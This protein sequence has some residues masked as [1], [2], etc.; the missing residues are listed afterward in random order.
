M[1]HVSY[2]ELKNWDT[3]AFYHKLVHIDKLKLFKGNEYTAFGNAIHD[4]CEQLLLNEKLEATEHFLESY[5]NVLN[6]LAKDNYD[7]NKKLVLDMKDQGLR[8]LP[9]VMPAL[10]KYFGSYEVVATEEMLYEPIE[11]ADFSFKG[12]IDLVVKTEDGR[13]H[14]IDWKTCSWGWNAKKKSDKM[15]VYQL[16]FYKHFYAS[17]HNIDPD[18]ID[19][20]FGLLKRTAKKNEVEL[21]KVSSGKKRTENALNFLE[22][23]L[24]NIVNKKYIKNKLACN[25]PFGPCEF[26]GTKHCP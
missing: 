23:A 24:Y 22:N 11:I 21:F 4:T 14:V 5:K 25:G 19:I 13:Y 7:F 17:K 6:G 1:P 12:Y 26:K 10:E 3:C 15:I 8:L 2:S 9:H 20:H 16:V 18:Q